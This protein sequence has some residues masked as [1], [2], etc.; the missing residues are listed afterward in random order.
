VK[1]RRSQRGFSLI[2]LMVVLAIVTIL[3]VSLA[4]LGS[5]SSATPRIGAEQVTGMVQVARLR[6][7]AKRQRHRIAITNTT[8]ELQEAVDASNEPALGFANPTGYLVVQSMDVPGGVVM[9]N[10]DT[11]TVNSAGGLNPGQNTSLSATIDFKPDGS[12]TGGTIYLTDP[13]TSSKYRIFVF[14]ATGNSMAREGW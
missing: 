12:S 4:T 2:E 7:E 9:W 13:Q 6:A 14:R 10:V 1:T 11:A 8:V 5:S 3:S